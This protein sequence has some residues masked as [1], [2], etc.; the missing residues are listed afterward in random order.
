[1]SKVESA[2][3]FDVFAEALAEEKG[4][5][6]GFSLLDEESNGA[7]SPKKHSRAKSPAAKP[8]GRKADTNGVE[9]EEKEADI[10]NLYFREMGKHSLIGREEE[11]GTY[12]RIG[13]RTSA[14]LRI[15][16]QVPMVQ[17]E[18]FRLANEI[19]T[20]ESDIQKHI[21]LTGNEDTT[22][23]EDIKRHFFIT[24][25]DARQIKKKCRGRS[26]AII[27]K[28]V[29]D[30]LLGLNWHRRE[31]SRF[32]Q[33]VLAAHQEMVQRASKGQ[34]LDGRKRWDVLA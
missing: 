21:H 1:M 17:K 11:R 15:I 9:E 2:E 12:R 20:G 24:I 5:V 25:R 28:K 29:V 19:F 7:F 8:K 14:M 23:L 3:I 34:K 4:F 30:Y 13:L 10:V 33:I 18:I 6:P 31:I 22:E 27:R 26:Q 32:I 16:F